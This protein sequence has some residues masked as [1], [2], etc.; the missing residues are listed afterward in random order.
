MTTTRRAILPKLTA[1]LE[2]DDGEPTTTAKRFRFP[3]AFTVLFGVTIAV[4]LLAFVVPTGA[5]QTDADSGR[6]I[7]GSYEATDSAF[8]FGDR[9]MELFMAPINGLYG[10]INADGYIGPYESGEL[11]GAAGVFLFVLAIGIFITM[12]M[13]TGAID[14]GVARVAQ[15]MSTRGALLIAVLMVLFSIG[16]TTEGM[17]EE[18]LGFYALLIPLMLALGY[19]RMVAAATILVGAGIGVLASTVNPFATGVGSGAADIS[20]G[21]GIGFRLLMYV[22]LVPVGVW[23]VLRYARKVKA[24]PTTSLVGQMEGDAELKAHGVREV[25]RLTGREKSVLAIVATTFAFMI[26]A[27]VPWAQV[28]QGPDAASYGWQLDWYFP[29]LAALFLLM[30][31]VVGLVGGLGEKGITNSVVKGAADFIGV[32]LIIVLARGVTVIMNNS[33]IT[34]TILHSMESVVGDTNSGVFGVLMFLINLPLAFLVPSTSGHGAL[35]M[36]ILAPLADFAGVSRA[37]VV[38]AFQSASGIV[39]LITPTSAVVMGGLA[40][41]RVRYD[42]YL[43]FVLPLVGILLV[44][45]AAFV[46]VGAAV[47]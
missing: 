6:P 12:A 5:Y 3:S 22:V 26:Y 27:I 42:Q 14:N 34:G 7:P 8:S 32:G 17:A 24:D 43:R 9:L 31:L 21:D 4:W 11:Y 44:L 13:K 15:R 16:G 41:A 33:E 1:G 19:D 10:V 18:T 20:I 25:S 30:A 36:P 23:W 39:N 29:E 38:T 35:A 45:C 28:I 37:M 47:S 40:L 2:A 46:G